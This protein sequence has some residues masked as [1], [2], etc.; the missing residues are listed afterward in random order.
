VRVALDAR[1]VYDAPRRGTGKT[2]VGLYRQLAVSQPAWR[3]DLFHQLPLADGDPLEGLPN[4]V[5]HRIDLPG[6]RWDSWLQ[7]GLPLIA[8]LTRSQVLH[9]PANI[10]PRLPLLPCVVTIHDLIP[11]QMEPDSRAT[12]RWLARVRR[13]ARAARRILTDSE[14]SRTLLL[15]ELA[16]PPEKVIVNHWAPDSRSVRVTDEATLHSV[17]AQYG[18]G[19]RPFLI[20]FGAS[21]ARKNTPRILEAWSLLP[22]EL[23]S[24]SRL[25]LIGIQREGL[26]GFQ[27]IAE[28]LGIDDT[29]VLRG[30]APDEDVPALLSAA[31]GLCY[32]SLCEGFGVPVL[33]AFACGAPVLTSNGTSLVEVAGDA[34]I[35]VEPTSAVAISD[36]MRQLLTDDGVR[37]RLIDRGRKRLESFKWEDCAS[38][39]AAV[40]EQ[41]VG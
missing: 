22:A 7:A 27:R 29:C 24:A 17:R 15:K 5:R 31:R 37:E 4:L 16:L 8:R 25:L 23:R 14:Y 21:A 18:I 28:R 19:H 30:Y 1:T 2:L 13:G 38:R 36:G 11:L 39:V 41:A 10:A 26:L 20:G 9:A 12:A 33:D 6:H 32:P 40:L 34:A 3:F 35:L